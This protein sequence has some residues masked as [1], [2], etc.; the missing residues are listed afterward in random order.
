MSAEFI[1]LNSRLT[2][3]KGTLIE[4]KLKVNTEEGFT[5]LIAFMALL[6]FLAFCIYRIVVDK[7]YFFIIQLLLVLI[8]LAPHFKRINTFLF[9]Q[10]WKSSIRMDY[11][12]RV[13][14]SKL[15]NGLETQVTLHL[16]N[17]RKKF[18]TFRDAEN[19]VDDFVR[20]IETKEIVS[21]SMTR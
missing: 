18:L 5:R 16:K 11:I 7:K 1:T 13:T 3:K 15:Q 12:Q 19:Q 20:T 17:G 2:I 10:T 14:S 4:K 9:V 8:W 6:A 21:A